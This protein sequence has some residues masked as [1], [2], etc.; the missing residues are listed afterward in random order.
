MKQA[1]KLLFVSF[2]VFI[3][4]CTGGSSDTPNKNSPPQF[5][6]EGVV[7]LE[8]NVDNKDIPYTAQ[9]NDADNDSIELSISGKN[10][11]DFLFQDG[12][13]LFQDRTKRAAGDIFEINIIATDGKDSAAQTIK[14][15]II[16]SALDD[17]EKVLAALA[18]GN[19]AL[20][21]ESADALIKLIRQ[22]A[23]SLPTSARPF[24]KY[25]D[26]IVR[27]LD[28]GDYSF[29]IS[30]CTNEI[31]GF[32]FAPRS[33]DQLNYWD[34]F[35]KA[36]I[37]LRAHLASLDKSKT[38][39]FAREDYRL[40]KLLI[41]LG[42]Y[43]R[44]DVN[45]PLDV[46]TSNTLEFLRAYFADVSVFH[47]RKHNILMPNMG[48]FSQ[49]DF[50]RVQGENYRLQTQSKRPMRAAGVYALPG[51]NFTVKRNDNSA[52]DVRVM[53]NTLRPGSLI[54]Y[55]PTRRY[56]GVL[57]GYV[58]P[59]W[60]TSEAFPIAPGETLQL[61]T[62]YGG[63]I[64][65]VYSSSDRDVDISFENIAH[66]PYW[67]GPEDTEH[68]NK[69]LASGIYNWV[70]LALPNL[71]LHSRLDRFTET[72]E[73]SGFNEIESLAEATQLYTYDMLHQAAGFQGPG[74]TK[75][76]GIHGFAEEKGWRINNIDIVKHI[77]AEMAACG[78]GCAAD[79]LGDDPERIPLDGDFYF[80]P[81]RLL[82]LHE[83][84]HELEDG[85]F[86][87][88]SWGYSHATT[89]IYASYPMSER[90]KS[91]GG[92]FNSCIK[93]WVDD[94]L[95]ELL[96]ESHSQPDP[97]AYLV[98]NKND[99]SSQYVTTTFLQFVLTVHNEG[100]I[101]N[102]WYLLPRLHML[103]NEYGRALRNDST[104]MSKRESLGFSSYS[105][106]E[107]QR[108]AMPKTDWLVIAMSW[109]SGL[110]LSGYASMWG[111]ET[112]AKAKA[113]ISTFGFAKAKNVFY[114]G[115]SQYMCDLNVQALPIDGKSEWPFARQ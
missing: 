47:N 39:I 40:Q 50:S 104:W 65:L 74:I 15:T 38:D 54:P 56:N 23:Q 53:I 48:V 32:F 94:N 72:L 27:R 30:E 10:A 75:N 61:S 70:E 73:K 115:E 111:Y 107:A 68:F 106:M 64:Q 109:V 22:E 99:K 92:E 55:R 58:R 9:V 95:Y 1:K 3:C 41:L 43:Y 62:P 31:C 102:G 84:G 21:P 7:S 87:F 80:H 77:N 19:P 67:N 52:V 85:Q 44:K 13:L 16:N 113:Q 96:Q 37:P 18:S 6:E 108:S 36:V 83:L 24:L 103:N 97:T 51:R 35:A 26:D 33:A 17:E 29:E 89:E 14:I 49:S 8:I 57:K 76:P 110:D 34:E 86:H 28:S 5:I 46:R 112:S 11:S 90:H 63:P 100:S 2:L 105:R 69:T 81:A 93:L 91:S 88:P 12:K 66:H 20:L 98:A 42:D 45:Y 59:K 101:G 78:V 4:G 71:E 60:V 79:T 25:M 82:Y 114:A